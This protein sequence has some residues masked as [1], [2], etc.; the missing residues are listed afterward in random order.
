MYNDNNHLWHFPETLKYG[1][2][3]L[4]TDLLNTLK[5]KELDSTLSYSGSVGP[6]NINTSTDLEGNKFLGA[7]FNKGNFG[8]SAFT[9]FDG[10]KGVQF[11]YRKAL[12]QRNRNAKGG[13]A[14]ILEVWWPIET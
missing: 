12:G 10:N 3:N 4:R 14:K 1:I 6:V 8:V 5:D 7:D 9:D 2:L 13:L 11:G